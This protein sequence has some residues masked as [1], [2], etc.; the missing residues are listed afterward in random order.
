[1][2]CKMLGIL[3]AALLPLAVGAQ[4]PASQPAPPQS[5]GVAQA[6]AQPEINPVSN[7]IRRILER[8]TKVVIAAAEQ[9]PAEKYSYRPTP[10]QM[11]FAHLVIHTAGTNNFLCANI[12]GAAAPA[13]EK[14]KDTDTKEKL[15]ASLKASF[16][17]C[18]QALAKV[19]DSK[20]GEQVPFF[21]GDKI[22][23]AG[24][25]MVLS[26]ALSDHYGMEAMYLR[27]NGMVPPTGAPKK[28]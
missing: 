14:L 13:D 15:V 4:Q 17:Y 9:M 24:A 10:D 11:T 1:M 3:A 20:L 25:M 18:T 16:A 26:S 6:T 22:S 19:D 12:S 27:L 23:Q 28:D 7:A 21:G 8:R 2:T 5:L